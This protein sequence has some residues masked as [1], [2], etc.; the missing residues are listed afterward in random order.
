MQLA[1][2]GLPECRR[3][4]VRVRVSPGDI[5]DTVS[6]VHTAAIYPGKMS[7]WRK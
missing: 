2:T 3:D 4:A 5:V 1:N 7:T 6:R